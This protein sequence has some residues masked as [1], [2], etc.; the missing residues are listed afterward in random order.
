MIAFR[1]VDPRP[2][3]PLDAGARHVNR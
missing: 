1:G 3:E 2:R